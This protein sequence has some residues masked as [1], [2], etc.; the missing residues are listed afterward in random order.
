MLKNV[1]IQKKITALGAD[2]TRTKRG[3]KNGIWDFVPRTKPEQNPYKIER[4]PYLFGGIDT[5]EVKQNENKSNT[6]SEEKIEL[7][8]RKKWNGANIDKL[9]KYPC[10]LTWSNGSQTR[11]TLSQA[12]RTRSG[13]TARAATVWELYRDNGKPSG[14]APGDIFLTGIAAAPVNRREY[15]TATITEAEKLCSI[16]TA[17]LNDREDGETC[18]P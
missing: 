5:Q 4:K 13:A 7:K 15:S 8:K 3:Q 14:A 16:Y 17:I 6:K 10:I 2:K 18:T 9:T 12:L 11:A 1:E